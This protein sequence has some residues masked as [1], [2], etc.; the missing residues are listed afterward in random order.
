M[1]IDVAVGILVYYILIM[2][3]LNLFLYS[4]QLVVSSV[5]AFLIPCVIVSIACSSAHRN[6][7]RCCH[8]HVVVF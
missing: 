5:C 7:C 3:S 4:G 8:L 1:C 6:F 2:L